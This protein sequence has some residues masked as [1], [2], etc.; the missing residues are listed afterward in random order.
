M[1]PNSPSSLAQLFRFVRRD[2]RGIGVELAQHAADGRVDQL[3]AIHLGGIVA[4]DLIDG[5]DEGFEEVVVG[6]SRPWGRGLGSGDR[7]N[8]QERTPAA[9]NAVKRASLGFA[10]GEGSRRSIK[11]S[12][13]VS[14]PCQSTRGLHTGQPPKIHDCIP[15]LGYRQSLLNPQDNRCNPYQIRHIALSLCNVRRL[16]VCCP[17]TMRRVRWMRGLRFYHNMF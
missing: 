6:V 1:P 14:K 5:V 17:E 15:C 8:C 11:G 9:R 13:S 7:R 2:V 3:A 12:G 10:P 16:V 4:L